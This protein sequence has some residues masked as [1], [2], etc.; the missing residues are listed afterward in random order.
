M[1]TALLYSVFYVKYTVFRK[2]WLLALGKGLLG[3][4]RV[5]HSVAPLLIYILVVI[6]F[7]ILTTL[8]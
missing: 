8:L 5:L 6:V 4:I 3:A 7:V 1:Q 2:S